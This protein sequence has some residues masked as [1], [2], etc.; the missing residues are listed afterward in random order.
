MVVNTYFCYSLL[1]EN[2][3]NLLILV[4]LLRRKVADKV[5]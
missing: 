2:L 5:S 3:T 1:L 4:S